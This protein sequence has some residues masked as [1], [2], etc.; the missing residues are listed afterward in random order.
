MA[1]GTFGADFTKPFWLQAENI[2]RATGH[3]GL[4][5]YWFLL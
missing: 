2:D 3:A 1:I 4:F 5:L